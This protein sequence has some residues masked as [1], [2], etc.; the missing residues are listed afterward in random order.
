MEDN[1]ILFKIHNKTILKEILDDIPYQRL[2]K[3]S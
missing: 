1:N 3:L 2:L